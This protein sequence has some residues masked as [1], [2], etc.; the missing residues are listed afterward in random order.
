MIKA[1]ASMI[2]RSRAT[3]PK[4]AKNTRRSSS[5]KQTVL[6]RSSTISSRCPDPFGHGHAENGR[7]QLIGI[8]SYR[9]RTL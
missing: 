9:S 6:Q 2:Q 8:H 4:S 5:T 7:V 3:T 1:Y